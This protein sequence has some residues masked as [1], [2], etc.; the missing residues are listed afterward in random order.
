VE[1]FVENIIKIHFQVHERL[2]KPHKKY[3]ER[4]DQHR[5]KKTFKVGYKFWLHL[6]K[7]RLQH[8]HKKIKALQYDPSD[9]LDKVGDNSSRRILT[10]YMN[11]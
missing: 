6:N 2:N 8:P 10:P 4:H 1:K 7:E 11:N 3:K 9:I 5:R